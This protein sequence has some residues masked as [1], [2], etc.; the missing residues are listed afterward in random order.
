M[1]QTIAC[2]RSADKFAIHYQ[3]TDTPSGSFWCGTHIEADREQSHAITVGTTFDDAQ[4][5]RGRNTD[6]H[7]ISQCPDGECCRRPPAELSARW[8][9]AIWPSPKARS[10]VLAALPPGPFPGVDMA[11][12]YEFVEQVDS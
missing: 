2:I 3:Y 9:H 6:N 11:E 1:C 4:Y 8:E 5:F 12:I 7:S 10:H